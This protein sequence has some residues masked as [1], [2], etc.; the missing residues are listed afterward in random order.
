M[1]NGFWITASIAKFYTPRHL[2]T[3]EHSDWIKCY[4]EKYQLNK[5]SP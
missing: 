2:Y 1:G 4:A 3:L 5:L